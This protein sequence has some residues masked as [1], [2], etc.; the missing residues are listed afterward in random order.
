MIGDY[1]K[2]IENFIESIKLNKNHK[3]SNNILNRIVLT[4]NILDLIYDILE[5]N[6]LNENVLSDD[7]S[8]NLIKLICFCCQLM[9]KIKIEDKNFK[10]SHYTK[11]GSL[12]FLLKKRAN[13]G[14]LRLN[15]AIYMNDPEEGQVFKKLLSKYKDNKLSKIFNNDCDIKNFTYLTCFCPYN[16]RDILPMWVHYGD[17]CKG[18]GLIFNEEFF[19][20]QDLHFIQYIDT[21]KFD[22]N[23]VDE[24]IREELTQIFEFLSQDIFINSDN[25]KFLEYT[26]IIIN[27]IS[28][29]FKDKAYEYE[30]EVRMVQFRNY[31]S[32]DIIINEAG[33]IP[34]LC[35]EYNKEITTENCE[36]I[37]VGP[38]G[39]FEEI[40]TYGKYIGIKR[41]AKSKIKY[42]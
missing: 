4:D 39:N 34:K 40:A 5:I 42:R 2:A 25:E 7:E 10:L 30:N 19:E 14:K 22:I 36:E 13:F 6:R 20:G 16:K 21:E 26:N 32:E 29:L 37:I 27:Y 24:N 15:N 23:E 38:K 31:E 1:T 28:Y 11:T 41:C 35:I 18:I 17:S 33:D 12:K 8:I 3:G 9:N